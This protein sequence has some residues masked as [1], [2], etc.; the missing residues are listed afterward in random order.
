MKKLIHIIGTGICMFLAS[1]NM[2]SCVDGNDWEVTP[3]NRLFGST[4]GSVNP[5]AITADI[6]WEATPSTEYYIIE[7]SQEALS[8]DQAMGTTTG[9]I[10]Y[11]EDKS[12][13]KS[14]YTLTG[15][16]SN[17]EYYLRIKSMSEGK[18]SRWMYLESTFK[19]LVEQILNNVAKE[20]IEDEAIRVTWKANLEVTHLFIQEGEAVPIQRDITQEEAETGEALIEGLTPGT[21]YVISIYNDEIKR[22]ELTVSTSMSAMADSEI[23]NITKTSAKLTWDSEIGK[24]THYAW[25]EG[26]KTPTTSDHYTALTDEQM[27][28]GIE[29]TGLQPSTTYTIAVMK[30]SYIRTIQ[31]FTTNKGIPAGFTKVVVETVDEWNAALSGNIGKVAILI[32]ES[33]MLDLTI[34]GATVEIPNTITSLLVWGVDANED[35][36]N[37]KPDFKTKGLKFNGS[38]DN[39]EFY[40]L[41]LLSNGNTGNYII[42]NQGS[43]TSNIKSIRM[44]SCTIDEARGVFRIRNTAASTWNNCSIHDCVLTKIG[45]YGIFSLDG[46]TATTFT[47]ISLTN[48]TVDTPA[49][50]ILKSKQDG[51]T[52]LIDKC[53]LYGISYLMLDTQAKKVAVKVSNTL[54]GGFKSANI[55]AFD[56]ATVTVASENV[57]TAS[58]CSYEAGKSWGEM[59]TIPTA[60]FFTTPAS[61]DFTVKVADYKT[62]GDPRWNK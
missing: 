20:D 51:F 10:V 18:E 24:I 39:I 52:V 14:P 31:T 44:E 35:K 28:S 27:A 32:P 40:N 36:A 48:S 62:Y 11:G 34:T 54:L 29:L 7:V 21:A 12:I 49:K 53:T 9:S 1:L 30:N 45:D 3:T 55:K 42:D 47:T 23:S 60:D 25:C 5:A 56:G 2:A 26:T 59:L 22:G 61:G 17:T 43:I 41:H 46:A 15:L 8:N 50:G 13:T 33:T 16:L 19:T 57:Y 38:F 6:S 37:N 4:K 58:D